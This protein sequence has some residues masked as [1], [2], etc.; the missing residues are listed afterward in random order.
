M[1]TTH[2]NQLPEIMT[3][4][5]VAFFLGCTVSTL[6]QLHREKRLCGVRLGSGGLRYTRE[7]LIAQLNTLCLNAISKGD[8]TPPPGATAVAHA[9][10]SKPVRR[11]P[12]RLVPMGEG[13]PA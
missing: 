12:P 4:S 5:E 1:G 10:T 8:C 2:V 3:A 6:E 11:T 13:A 9:T 7:A